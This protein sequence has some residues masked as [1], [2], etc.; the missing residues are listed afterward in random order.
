MFTFTVSVCGTVPVDPCQ[1]CFLKIIL[2]TIAL[3]PEYAQKLPQL[4][5]KKTNSPI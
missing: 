2:F 3:A 5:N 4:N 1:Y